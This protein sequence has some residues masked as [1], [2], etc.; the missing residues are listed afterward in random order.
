MRLYPTSVGCRPSTPISV[1]A[2]PSI[3]L[4]TSTNTWPS[5]RLMACKRVLYV[6][7]SLA[8]TSAL[9]RPLTCG[10]IDPTNT[11]APAACAVRAR[12]ATRSVEISGPAMFKPFT[13]SMI[14][15]ASGRACCSSPG[16]RSRPSS[17]VSPTTPE[18]ITA[19][20]DDCV[21]YAPV[22]RPCR[23][24]G[25]AAVGTMTSFV[26]PLDA[27]GEVTS[28]NV[29]LSPK[30]MNRVRDSVAGREGP[31]GGDQP[32]AVKTAQQQATHNNGMRMISSGSAPACTVLRPPRRC[33]P[34]GPCSAS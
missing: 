2:S 12:P 29:K 5:W 9:G 17:R 25:Y 28:P 24:D 3:A 6:T 14:S 26:R 20:T 13:P 22:N 15:T 1:P 32:Q 31:V 21:G 7:R 33:S 8:G 10:S 11:R 4:Y 27:I 19:I 16:K 18:L 23:T 34:P 30:A